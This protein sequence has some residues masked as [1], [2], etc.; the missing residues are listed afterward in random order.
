[1]KRAA[2]LIVLVLV[3]LAAAPAE[4]KG[5]RSDRASAEKALTKVK[6]LQ[7]GKGV[8]TGR[9]LTPALNRLYASLQKLSADDRRAAEGILARPDDSQQDPPGTH[10][11]DPGATVATPVCGAHFCIHYVTDTNDA[12]ALTDTSPA[13]GIPDYVAQMLDV[14]ENEVYP[15]ENGTAANVC[16]GGTT[17]GLGWRDA[18]PDGALG[19]AANKLDVYIENLFVDHIFG[20]VAIDPGQDQNPAVPHFAYM[21]MDKDFSRFGDGSPAA[22]T[23]NMQ[24]TAAHEY[25]HV[26]QNAYDYLED[27]WMFEAT[28]VYMED[29][30]YPAINDYLQYLQPWVANTGQPITAFPDTNLKP[31]GSAVWNHWL[32]H[33]YGPALVRTAWE[34]SVAQGDFAP[35]AYNSAIAGAGGAGFLDEFDRFSATVAEWNAPGSGFPDHYPDVPRAASL[36]AGSQTQ[37][38]SLPHTTFGLFDVPVPSASTIRLTGTL[39]NGTAGAI[40]LVGRTGADPNAGSVTSNVVPMPS[41]GT[42]VVSLDNPSQFGR[43]TAVV[44]N[45][46]PS[47]SGFSPAAQDWIF[48]KDA[49]GVVLALAQPGPPVATTGNPGPISD[50]GAVVTGTVDPHLSDTTWTFEYGTTTAYGSTTPPQ[51]V[52]GSTVGGTAVS[53]PLADLKPNTAYHYRLVATNASGS[54]P[55]ADMMFFTARDVTKPIVSFLVKRQRLK[56]VRAR[57]LFYTGKCSERCLGTAQLSVSRP[58]ARKLHI[59]T[60]LGKANITLDVKPDPATLR[61]GL[62]AKAKK[63]LKKV[64]KNVKATLKIKVADESGNSVTVTRA[65]TLGR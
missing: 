55:G 43:I 32:D 10:K 3:P 8:R 18:A 23:A 44:V 65:V 21:V 30:V 31:Y 54:T 15:C 5:P 20:Y 46:D 63:T 61:V 29:K 50:H 42:A 25:N 48:T 41:G 11:W 7:R 60:S 14:F 34:Q 56:A 16:G 49:T 36:P 47:R 19:G 17:P 4:A 62:T 37:P 1:M 2:A 53:A 13:D 52:A 24:V 12:P 64:K 39:P 33:R 28:A 27:P 57:G 38:F 58:V 40:A 45:S 59:P 6:N 22:N 26:L 35:G 51:S 9:E